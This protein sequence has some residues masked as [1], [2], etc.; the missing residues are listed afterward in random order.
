MTYTPTDTRGSIGCSSLFYERYKDL[1]KGK[2]LD[3]GCGENKFRSLLEADPNVDYTGLDFDKNVKPDV[4]LTIDKECV[5]PFEDKTF[6]VVFSIH[7]LDHFDWDG[8]KRCIEEISRVLKDDG[9]FLF[10]TGSRVDKDHHITFEKLSTLTAIL[11][12]GFSSITIHRIYNDRNMGGARKE[13]VKGITKSR[14]EDYPN[15]TEWRS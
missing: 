2:V 8:C 1:I 10:E 6:D 3:I 7:S 12:Y 11:E 14:I 15:H 4:C 5:L 13:I 9:V